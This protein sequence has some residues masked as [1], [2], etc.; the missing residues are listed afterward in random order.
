MVVLQKSTTAKTKFWVSLR[1]TITQHS[2][3]EVLMNS[4]IDCLSCGR[5]SSSSG[6]D[7]G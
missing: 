3:E 1:F 2:R 6:R 4:L 5:F 7:E